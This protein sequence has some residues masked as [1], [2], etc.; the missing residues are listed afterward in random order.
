MSTRVRPP[1]PERSFWGRFWQFVHDPEHGWPTAFLWLASPGFRRDI[2]ANDD[3]YRR[4]READ[5]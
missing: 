3:W 4:L 1:I 5:R 2:R